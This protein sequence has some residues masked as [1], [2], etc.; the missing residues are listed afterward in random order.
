MITLNKNTKLQKCKNHNIVL[1]SIKQY[2][3]VFQ[4]YK[5]SRLLKQIS[6]I[7]YVYYICN[8]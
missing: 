3:L 7:D 2:V 4:K 6:L 1:L 5:Y 8:N